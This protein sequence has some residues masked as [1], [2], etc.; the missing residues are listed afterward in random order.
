MVTPAGM[1][2]VTFLMENADKV[3]VYSDSTHIFLQLRRE[4]PT[5]QDILSPSFK[6]AVSLNEDTALALASELLSIVV[7]RLKASPA[8]QDEEPD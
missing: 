4:V 8:N 5:Q 3:L 1:R 6:V 2:Q 7:G